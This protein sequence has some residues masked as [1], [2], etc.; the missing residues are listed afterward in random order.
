MAMIADR[1][2]HVSRTHGGSAGITIVMGGHR[3]D[4]CRL[5][6]VGQATST[7]AIPVDSWMMTVDAV[8]DRIRRA[9]S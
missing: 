2:D 9:L 8:D 5:F 6:P 1:L 7:R 3:I 4:A